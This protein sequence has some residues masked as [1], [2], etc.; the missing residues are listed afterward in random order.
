MAMNFFAQ[1]EEARRQT[2][3]LVFWFVL[4]VL[5][6]SA[7]MY[8]VTLV[9]AKLAIVFFMN[10]DLH[11]AFSNGQVSS[12]LM[13]WWFPWMFVIVTTVTLLIILSGSLIKMNE[14]RKGGGDGL[15]R[16]LGGVPVVGEALH[17]PLLRRLLN[18]VDEMA[19]ASGIPAPPVYVLV[20]A[21]GINAFAAGFTPETAVV[22]VTRGA[23]EKL[24]RDELQGVIA[25]EFSH[26]IN[27]DMLLNLRLLGMTSGIEM[28]A[29]Y[30]STLMEVVNDDNDDSIWGG[31]SH[32]NSGRGGLFLFLVGGSV[33]MLGSVGG[34]MAQLIKA[35]VSR[36]REFLA[37]AA[38]VQ[39]TRNPEGL[40]RALRKIRGLSV[41]ETKERAESA[42]VSHMFFSASGVCLIEAMESHPPL[43]VR[44][45]NL[46]PDG[47]TTA[48][49][50]K[51]LM[52]VGGTWLEKALLSLPRRSK[53]L[54]RA[55]LPLPP[56]P[57]QLVKR[58]SGNGDSASSASFS[59]ASSVA[60]NWAI[61]A[62][63]GLLPESLRLALREPLTAR[64]AV[65]G[66]MGG[67]PPACLAGLE[68]RFRLLALDSSLSA[69]R[70]L[71]PEDQ[72]AL[73][74]EA[75]A[76]ADA[77][78]EITLFEYA[79]LRIL[80]R[81]IGDAAV[82]GEA[83][84]VRYYSFLEVRQPCEVLVSTMSWVGA[85]GDAAEATRIFNLGVS[86]L[87]TSAIGVKGIMPVDACTLDAVDQAIKVISHMPAPMKQKLV[88][89]GLVCI[90]ADRTIGEEESE[91]V[92]AIAAALGCRQP[93]VL[94]GD[95]V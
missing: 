33:Y 39:F 70:Q 5:V 83:D 11:G 6:V 38:A 57:D 78:A 90:G 55:N 45:R 61:K 80:D 58:L 71:P 40:G 35:A 44:I 92:R 3:R 74:A 47:E 24:D 64:A 4:A 37:D 66:L 85:N 26:I 27:G 15:A 86:R 12:F 82:L 8:V 73:R 29:V 75:Q 51:V 68:P 28:L 17:D 42:V 1:Q 46:L 32:R 72:A 14:L 13:G 94:P 31:G 56:T 69:L 21:E 53:A 84:K 25:H 63:Q 34:W 23:V 89:A 52:A 59:A 95:K 79:V 18:I 67:A 2:R 62:R 36:Q 77:D 81:A 87:G 19:I 93:P 48:L 65:L 49:Y 10:E 9:A 7:A 50:P 41:N 16:S 91:L 20:E 22:A 76:L 88:D 30:G 43:D 60:A 54:F